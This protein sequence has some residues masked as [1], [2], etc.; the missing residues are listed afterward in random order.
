LRRIVS[1]LIG[2]ALLLSAV[3]AVAQ[4]TE[5]APSASGRSS[6]AVQ[7][8]ASVHLDRNAFAFIRYD[9]HAV[10]DPHQHS[11]AVEGSIELRNV[12]KQPRREVVLQISSSLR[13]LSIQQDGQPAE[14]IEQDFTSDIDHTGL[15][16]EAIVR[17]SA[18]IA[19]DATVRLTVRYAG[20]VVKDATRLIRIG[21]PESAALR[22]DWDEIS[23]SFTALRGA[24]FVTWY[25]V[26]M[27]A[28]N[29]AAGNELF[30]ILREWREREA[31]A[32]LRLHLTRAPLAE[33]EASNYAFF[34]DTAEPVSGREITAEFRG[35]T[36]VVVLLDS[37]SSITNRPQV[38]AYFNTAHTNLARDYVT[39]AEAV[40]APLEEWL[41]RSHGKAVI[42]ELADPNALPYDDGV[43]YFVPLR[44]VKP[45][46]AEVALARPVART[47][48]ASPRPWIRE[49]LAAFAQAIVRERQAGHRAALDY[50][51]QF[52][53][54]LAVA[55][56][57]S[58]PAPGAAPADADQPKSAPQPLITTSDELYLRTKAAYVW[59]MLRDIIGD[60]ALKS[61]L[62][63][64]RAEDDRNPAYLQ[65]LIQKQSPARRDLETFFDDWVY[66]D[67][68]LPRLRHGSIN[69]RK[70][71]DEQTVTAIT[72][73][74]LGDAWCE[75]PVTVRNAQGENQARVAVPAY[76]KASVRIPFQATPTE[77]EIND[78][79]VP[80]A[81]RRQTTLPIT[82]TP[83]PAPPRPEPPSAPEPPLV[84]PGPL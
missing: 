50:L 62:A 12:S 42:V 1:V 59:W 25:P 21:T 69:I 53:N 79:S 45:A 34:A 15:L 57:A 2:C 72:I 11:L 46:A 5:A 54:A 24:G 82:A 10:I 81:D 76:G 20:T 33:G 63:H 30:D 14:W 64:Y 41:G 26:S 39:A 18:P 40:I 31:T 19:P 4:S 68:G 71:L 22:S 84:K 27:E 17:P 77:L 8:G 48:I 23:D 60:D 80:E 70:T 16:R 78:G 7:L 32:E 65:Q 28:A 44:P 67:R 9:L 43:V 61:A 51:G 66:R 52:A 75:V 36:P 38:A 55:E 56:S 47:M 58:H 29:L 13:W 73:E 6:E 49:G 83:A 74:N 37:A 35:E 3:I